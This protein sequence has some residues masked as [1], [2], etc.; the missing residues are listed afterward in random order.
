MKIENRSKS[1]R[2]SQMRYITA[3]IFFPLLVGL[4]VTDFVDEQ[5]FGL[6][7]YYLA[8]FATLIYLAHNVYEY[9]K[10]F[11][12]I[13]F[14][15]E[16]NHKILL[17]YVSL[18]PL[19]NK[20]YSVEIKKSDLHSYKISRSSMNLRQELILY[21][22]TPQGIAKYPP[23]SITALSEDELN[24]MKKALNKVLGITA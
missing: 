12:Y 9:I 6:S 14:S 8:I 18:M 3:I 4:L 7:K 16:E 11:N 10:D 1:L 2:I 23:V 22:R 21:V 15:D 5:F 17:R 13:Y 24:Q 20:K 19:K